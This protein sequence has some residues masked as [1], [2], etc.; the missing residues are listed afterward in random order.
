MSSFPSPRAARLPLI[1]LPLLALSGCATLSQIRALEHVDFSIDRLAEARLAGVD[2][3]RIESFSDLGF[4]DGARLAAA[5]AEGEL[6]LSLSLQILAENPVDNLAD[7]RLVQMDWTLL[8]E[9]RETVSGRLDREIVLPRGEGTTFPLAIDLNLVDFFEGN[10]RELF[11]LAASLSGYGTETTQI[12][13][14]AL[15][16]IQTALGPISYSQPIRI[17]RTTVGGGANNES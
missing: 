2:V 1:A 11:N 15:P 9:D 5:V 10:A 3:M 14:R 16:T 12:E 13:L 7:A 17:V 6:P 4:S 8:L